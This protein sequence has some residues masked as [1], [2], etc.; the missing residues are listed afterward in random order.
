[1]EGKPIYE[2]ASYIPSD[3]PKYAYESTNYYGST[4][5]RNKGWLTYYYQAAFLKVFGFS[6]FNARLPFVLLFCITAVFVY[7][8]GKRLF[9]TSVGLI[10]AGL[11]A[12]NYFSI[13]YEYQA[14]YY[15]VVAA[16]SMLCLY[17]FYRALKE[18]GW[19]QYLCAALSLALLFYT[20]VT[21]F[22]AML[23]LFILLHGYY[24]RSVRRIFSIKVI[25]AV[26]VPLA[27]AVPWLVV[28]KFWNVFETVEGD[29]GKILWS[30][31]L[32]ALLIIGLALKRLLP[33]AS[34]HDF[35][36]FSPINFILMAIAAVVIVKPLV[37]PE[38][39]IASRLFVELNPLFCLLF[40]Y[41]LFALF[42]HKLWKGPQLYRAG[43]GLLLIVIAA[44]FFNMFRPLDPGMYESEWV[45]QS[46]AYLDAHGIS[47]TAPIF[48]GYQQLPFMLYSDYNVDLVWP[49]RKEFI[50]AYGQQ[51]Y[52]IFNDRNFWPQIFYRERV[53]SLEEL[54]YYDRAAGCT[55]L[56]VTEDTTLYSCP[57]AT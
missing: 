50:D 55:A 23:L 5:E 31:V 22:I 49:I 56:E 25:V 46:I 34:R 37:T 3:D 12:V 29:R 8:L 51:M 48:V 4:Y 27:A 44:V 20:H 47:K 33:P 13:F 7:L 10:A 16:V 24:H 52:F 6:T 15:A 36:T 17:F 39:S 28:V 41:A 54:N 9:T 42:R 43:S 19:G 35:K 32:V 21:A 30:V 2:N 53:I 40:S 11:H 26:L 14:R 1:F 18:S 38:E 57:A 45:E